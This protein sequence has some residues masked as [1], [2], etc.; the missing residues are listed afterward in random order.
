MASS[1]KSSSG[2]GKISEGFSAAL[3]ST[4]GSDEGVAGVDWFIEQS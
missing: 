1:W 2:N 3:R 4:S